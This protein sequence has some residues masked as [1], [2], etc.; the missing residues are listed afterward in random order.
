MQ[1]SENGSQKLPDARIAGTS[2][3]WHKIKKVEEILYDTRKSQ[4]KKQ[5]PLLLLRFSPYQLVSLILFI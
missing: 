2:D 1:I 4:K 3:T 5:I